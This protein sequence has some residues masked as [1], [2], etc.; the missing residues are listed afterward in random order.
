VAETGYVFGVCLEEKGM[1]ALRPAM[2][3]GIALGAADSAFA[4]GTTRVSVDSSGTEGNS[5]SYGPSL[6]ADGQIVAFYSYASNLV[7]ADT[8]SA[9]DVFVIDRKT[10]QT[11]RVSVGW[12]GAEANGGSYEPSIS[13]DG[14]YIA[15]SSDAS[16][17]VSDDTNSSTD[18]F[19]YDTMVGQ[20][21]R[22]SVDSGGGEGNAVSYSSAIS[23]N[24][25]V[26]VFTSLAS[27]LVAG[28]TN[29]VWDVFVYEM[30][31]G[32]TTRVSVD[33]S[34]SEANYGSGSSDV[35]GDG[36]IIT[37]CSY[38]SNLVAND[39][40]YASDVFV[41]DRASGQTN[42]VSVDSLGIEGSLASYDPRI[43]DDGTLVVFRSEASNL[44]SSD[45][46][47]TTDIFVRDRLLGQTTR[48]SV[49]SIGSESNGGSFSPGI[50][51]DGTTVSFSSY[52]SNLVSGDTNGTSDIF[53]RDL[54]TGE[55]MV[56]SMSSAG[57]F[58]DGPC[59]GSTSVSGDGGAVAFESD[60][61][62]LVDDDTNGTVDAFVHE[63][64]ILDASWSNYG[65]GFP[66]TNGVPAFTAQSNPVLGVSLTLDL[67]NSYG[68][69]TAGLLF[70]GFQQ[71][72]IHSGWGGDLLVVP[73]ITTPIGIP[74]GGSSFT[75]TI[76]DDEALCGFE[77]DLQAIE[78]DPGAAK[79]VSF[80]QG[81]ELI[82]GR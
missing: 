17:L 81:L 70:I 73:V 80:S 27:N 45:N 72:T 43:S 29:A 62:N 1:N 18:A 39:T 33:S 41:H 25:S 56:A 75:G 79:G 57:I 42:R 15:F 10:G 64:C 78:A 52:G 38:A 11:T 31:T 30:A 68:K 66:G 20:T 63:R 32:A 34:G 67:A 23:S 8:N 36:T 51:A 12:M 54:V 69:F 53:M 7:S 65:S 44:V 82:L 26:V 61:T 55:T 3:V 28:D 22:V 46:N 77:I 58:G 16:N 47:G 71:T 2:I 40:N 60:A 9:S 4:Q 5:Y 50:S 37:F 13:A 48:V 21:R 49:D 14:R 6:S 59:Y 19:V 35:S 76:P 74:A 24:G